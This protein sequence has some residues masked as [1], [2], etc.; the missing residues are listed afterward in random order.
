MNFTEYMSEAVSQIVWDALRVS[1]KNHR[2]T[3]FLLKYKAAQ[4]KA[5]KKRT[6]LE[7]DGIHIPPFIIAS[8]ASQ[9][10]LHCLGCY[11]RANHV[12]IDNAVQNEMKSERWNQIFQEASDLGVSF[13][14][15][16]GGEP[17]M[18]KDVLEMAATYPEII[19]PIFTNGT[20]IDNAY[21]NLFNKNR[22]LIPVLSIEG[23][24]INTDDRRGKGTF[25]ILMR[26]MEEMDRRMIFYGVSITATKQ[27]ISFVSGK[28]F[29]SMLHDKGCKIVFYVEYVA[30]DGS[31]QLAPGDEDRYVLAQ[32]L[33]ELR[34]LYQ[35]M[36]FLS[37]PGEEEQLGGCLAAG[38]GFFH[39]NPFGA[40]EPCPFSPFSDMNLKNCSLLQAI[41]SPLFKK[42]RAQDFLS[43]KHDG[44]C[45]LFAQESKIKEIAADL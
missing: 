11:A 16:A 24:K 21:L 18:K 17:L 30:A 43:A 3:A 25:E 32:N 19:F 14:L 31:V 15:L 35:N 12:C 22:N 7:T 1:I 39:I 6:E 40:A 13:I 4:K 26:A 41:G 10:N 38:K 36:I 44:G 34:N 9:C 28:D 37:F 2:E 8:I 33:L 20:V 23:D 5:A 42:I 45:V 27:N 29:I